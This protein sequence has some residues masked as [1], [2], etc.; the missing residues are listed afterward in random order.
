[1]RTRRLAAPGPRHLRLPRDARPA[2]GGAVLPGHGRR[3]RRAQR[4]GTAPAARRHRPRVG[5]V[6]RERTAR[7][8]LSASSRGY[9]RGQ[10][11]PRPQGAVLM[12]ILA[13]LVALVLVALVGLWVRQ[14][15][16]RGQVR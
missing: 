13:F 10:V 1:R 5:R 8:L 11:R 14:R 4:E 12:W 7:V 9:H 3:V 15:R 16:T 6:G 2:P